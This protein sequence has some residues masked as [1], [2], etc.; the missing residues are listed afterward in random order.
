[1]LKC[2]AANDCK[3]ALLQLAT[4]ANNTQQQAMQEQAIG[5][6]AVAYEISAS[7]Y[8]T[9]YCTLCWQ[10]AVSAHEISKLKY[11]VQFLK[12]YN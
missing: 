6:H 9:S 10:N 3:P 11:D 8:V 1:M 2:D 5:N 4:I 12:N 7:T